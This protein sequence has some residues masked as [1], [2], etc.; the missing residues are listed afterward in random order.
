MIG[1]VV[2][3]LTYLKILQPIMLELH[4]VGQKYILYHYD[5]HR[6]MKEYNRATRPK[7][8][9]SSKEMIVN[10]VGVKAFRGEK[11]LRKHLIQDKIKKMVSLEIWL[12]AG[13][14]IKFF[15]KHGIKLYSVMYL[16]DSMWRPDPKCITAMDRVYY[17]ARHI[18]KTHH[19]FAGVKYNETRD[20]C[21]G[22]P[23]FDPLRRN[24]KGGNILVLLPNLQREY[25][26]SAFGGGGKLNKI[27][28]KI[29]AFKKPIFKA[30][31]K[32]WIP[33]IV[34][35][36]Q[37]KVVFD[38]KKM[39]P[40]VISSLFQDSFTTVMF[41]SSG[42]Y[43][44][45]YAGNYVINITLPIN[46]WSWDKAKLREYFSTQPP[47]LYNFD[48]VVKSYTQEKVLL[49]KW[50]FAPQR[51]DEDRRKDW[52]KSF[53]GATDGVENIVWDLIKS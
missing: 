26:K 7:M 14:Y 46:R 24:T 48:G 41:F 6:G 9:Q 11:D 32:Q 45:V 34:R 50:K 19:K 31:Q 10:A 37:A 30:R 22:S 1:I 12:W 43:E 18:M 44:C 49:N 40:P 51:V 16:T 35:K 27:I 25:V 53:I 8:E 29:C 28:E 2:R 5:V 52:V 20:R 47:S 23:V 36:I 38:G 15:K 17:S 39:Y 42:I 3:E 4:R 33:D 13:K 21:I